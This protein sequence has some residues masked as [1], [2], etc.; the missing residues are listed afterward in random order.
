MIKHGIEE[1]H[2]DIRAHVS[3]LGKQITVYKTADMLELLNKNS[4]KETVAFQP[5]WEDTTSKGW[6]V[7]LKDIHTKVVLHSSVFEWHKFTHSSMNLSERGKMAVAAVKCAILANKFPLWVCGYTT[8]DKDLDIQGTDIIV[9]TQR[10]IQVK[11]DWLSCPRSKGGSGNL[12]I[13]THE[14]NPLKIY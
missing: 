1:E 11:Y 12:Y 6:L 4:Y 3:L 5:G 14:C 13:Q 8:N 2:S 9:D 7:P 10:H